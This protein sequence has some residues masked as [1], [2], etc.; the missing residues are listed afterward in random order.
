MPADPRPRLSARLR[1]PL[2]L[3]PAQVIVLAFGAAVTIGTFLLMLP[4][5]TRGP[6][7]STFVDAL[8]HATSAV[9]VTG[10]SSVD[11]ANHWTV[12]GQV[13]LLVLIQI[14]GLGIMTF[15]SILGLV[16]ARRLG[17]RTRLQTARES[18]VVDQG[19]LR[20]LLFGVAKISISVELVVALALTLRWWLGYDYEFARALWLGVFH[21]I[22]AFNNAGF[23]LWTDNLMGFA[24]DAWICIPICVGVILGGLGFPVMLEL[25]REL[26]WTLHWTL[27]TK[28]VVSMT[29]ALL[30]GGTVVITALEWS[31]P[32]TLGALA[33]PARILAGFT[34]AVM[35]RTAGFNTVDIA[36][37]NPAT[38]FAMDA[39]M[40][41]GTG[42]A[43]T[44]GGIKVTTFA[45]ILFIVYAEIRG[46]G[47]VNLFGKRLPRS[48]QREAIT[49]AA[50]SFTVITFGTMLLMLLDG[51]DLDRSLFEVT[52]AFTT[53]GLT[54]GVTGDLS[55][56]AK[57]VLVFLMFAG[58]L[59][60]ITLASA[61]ALRRSSRL[62][63]YPKE[64]PIIG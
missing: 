34:Q 60:P 28:I 46:E 49:V 62:Y 55:P 44:G 45:V 48:A 19:D 23:A 38:W 57:V 13:V 21:S 42:P 10:L 17:L 61:I 15:A 8:F 50:L 20:R 2:Q 9:C 35:P 22:T 12:F 6:G 37:L 51:L 29:A 36:E 24:S 7:G 18:S 64:R 11:T 41:I 27:N 54:A 1:A 25:R 39:L 47:A 14:G 58:R 16:V 26:R 56:A 31:N 59:G 5:S 53:T 40:F 3:H 32:G 63:E 43:G 30:L 4:A 52:S 33:P